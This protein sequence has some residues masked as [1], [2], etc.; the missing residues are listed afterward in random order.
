MPIPKKVVQRALTKGATKADALA[1]ADARIALKGNRNAFTNKLLEEYEADYANR[2]T[3]QKPLLDFEETTVLAPA[4]AIDELGFENFFNRTPEE[5]SGKFEKMWDPIEGTKQAIGVPN[6]WDVKKLTQDLGQHNALVER[7]FANQKKNPRWLANVLEYVGDSPFKRQIMFHTDRFSDPLRHDSF[8]QY[9]DPKE[10]GVHLGIEPAA[11]RFYGQA[12]GDDFAIK[13]AK[14]LDDDINQL[15]DIAGMDPEHV[16]REI[17]RAI[18][19]GALDQFEKGSFNMSTKHFRNLKE[20]L[21]DSFSFFSPDAIETQDFVLQMN[22]LIADLN[23]AP[24]PNLTPVIFRGKN[25]LYLRDTKN[26]SPRSVGE[27]LQELFW[28]DYDEIQAAMDVSGGR[29]EQTKA[30]RQYIENK[31]YDHIIYHN[32]VESRGSVSIINW[33]PDLMESIWSPR[34]NR[35]NPNSSAQM[36]AGFIMGMLGLGEVQRE[37]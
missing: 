1:E 21:L 2:S 3:W 25:G 9:E 32:S 14:R 7:I 36:Y 35:D 5:F 16:R 29:L 6:D 24:T 13:L 11:A 18:E 26:F 34:F 23:S 30:L 20:D 33:N 31:G 37:E 17:G 15:A 8:I 22:D 4:P 19:K 28:E 12:S 10:M 27:Q